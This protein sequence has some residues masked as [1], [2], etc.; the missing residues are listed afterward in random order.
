MG[1]RGPHKQYIRADEAQ[2]N[3]DNQDNQGPHKQYI[4]AD[5]AQVHVSTCTCTYL[6][7]NISEPMKLKTED[8]IES[9]CSV[10][11][12]VPI[13]VRVRVRVGVSES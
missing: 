13:T 10:S 3:Q 1:H 5:E 4:R 7:S 6:I 11:P 2:D 8:F 9:A 12:E